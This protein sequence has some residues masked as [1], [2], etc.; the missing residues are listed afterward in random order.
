MMGPGSR[1]GS[2]QRLAGVPAQQ[3]CRVL[4]QRDQ[5]HVFAFLPSDQPGRPSQS[6]EDHRNYGA[7]VGAWVLGQLD[8]MLYG[9]ESLVRSFLFSQ[10][11]CP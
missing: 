7:G 2:S 3:F 6:C 10:S 4:L 11:S 5:V 8:Q 1:A 9:D